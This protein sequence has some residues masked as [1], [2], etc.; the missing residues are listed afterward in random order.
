MIG[1][2]VVASGSLAARLPAGNRPGRARIEL[3]PGSSVAE[4]LAAL[5][6][7]AER[8]LLLV[9]NGSVVAP[10]ARAERRLADGDAVSLA[11]PIRAG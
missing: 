5:D 4:L 6:V 9:L 10:D 11:P 1:V 7:P 3:P 2:D 8:P